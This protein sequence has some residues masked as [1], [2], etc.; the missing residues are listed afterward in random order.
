MFFLHSAS[1]E[2]LQPCCLGTRNGARKGT[3]GVCVL[4][5][6]GSATGGFRVNLLPPSDPPWVILVMDLGANKIA[7]TDSGSSAL[8][9]Q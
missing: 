7:K 2:R 3:L 1:I 5:S 8:D 4:L 6:N 9:P